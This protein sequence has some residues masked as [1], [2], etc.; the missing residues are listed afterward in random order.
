VVPRQHTNTVGTRRPSPV[1]CVA[2]AGRSV[3]AHR[4]RGTVAR[5]GVSSPVRRNVQN[6]CNTSRP[7]QEYKPAYQACLYSCSVQ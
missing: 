6:C 2:A 4:G 1:A 3:V 5:V 7:L